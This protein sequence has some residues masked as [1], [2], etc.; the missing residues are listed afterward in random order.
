VCK[1]GISDFSQREGAALYP[2]FFVVTP[3]LVWGNV[4][5]AACVVW[6]VALP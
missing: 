5:H 6:L 2:S 4:L 3:T 1:I